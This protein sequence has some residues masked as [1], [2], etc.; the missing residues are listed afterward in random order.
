MKFVYKNREFQFRGYYSDVSG[1][2]ANLVKEHKPVK[3]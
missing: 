1:K 3:A 2:N